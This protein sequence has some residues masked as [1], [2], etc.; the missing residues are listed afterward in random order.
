MMMDY[1][2]PVIVNII[3]V[4]MHDGL[5]WEGQLDVMY[6]DLLEAKKNITKDRYQ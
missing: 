1:D 2:I 6:Y 4:N 3:K 5:I